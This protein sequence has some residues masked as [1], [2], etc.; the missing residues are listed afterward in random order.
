MLE[1]LY[2]VYILH[3]P[4]IGPFRY[5]SLPATEHGILYR[6]QEEVFGCQLKHSVYTLQPDLSSLQLFKE[7]FPHLLHVQ[8]LLFQSKLNDG[9][10]EAGLR[11]GALN[12]VPKPAVLLNAA[13]GV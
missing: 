9:A 12:A 1:V 6:G 10:H 13:Y 5:N 4:N 11:K 7:A 8:R 3:L 2:M